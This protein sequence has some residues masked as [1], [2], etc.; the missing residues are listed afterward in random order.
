MMTTVAMALLLKNSHQLVTNIIEL[1][2]I[3]CP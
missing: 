1:Q 3:P 2:N